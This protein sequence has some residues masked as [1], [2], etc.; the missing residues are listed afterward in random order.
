MSNLRYIK[1]HISCILPYCLRKRIKKILAWNKK[2][3]NNSIKHKLNELRDL[4]IYNHPIDQIPCATGKLRLLQQGNTVL[5]DIFSKRC[6]EQG[7]R[8]WL[9][10]GTLLGAIRH[11]G[12]I[13]WDDDLDVGMLYDDYIKLVEKLPTMFPRS[14]GFT[15]TQHAFIQIGYQGTPLNIDI[16]PHFIQYQSA[17][18]DNKQKLKSILAEIGK[19]IVFTQGIVNITEPELLEIINKQ[20]H[21]NNQAHDISI[22]PLVFVSPAAAIS[23]DEIYE[24]NDIF[25][26]KETLFENKKLSIPNCSRKYLSNLFGDYMTYPPTVGIWHSHIAE[27]IKNSPFETNVNTFIDK[28]GQ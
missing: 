2:R 5:L 24:Y 16:F 22:N 15:H 10:Y 17:T 25:P 26:L 6:N 12:F 27:M 7:I 4:I 1:H 23:G 18:K 20:I 3:R 28:Y 8:Y 9:D 11:K 14:E 19:K 13:P 21:K